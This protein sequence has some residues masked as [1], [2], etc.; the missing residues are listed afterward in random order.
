[1]GIWKEISD[2]IKAAGNNCDVVRRKYLRLLQ[3]YTGRN[4]I[5]YV[6]DFLEPERGKAGG[7]A[8]LDQNDKEGFL[9]IL[10]GLK[11]DKLDVLIHS[12]GGSA[13]AAEAIVTILRNQFA[14]IRFIIPNVAKSAAT[15]LAM[16]GNALVLDDKS[17]LGPI[18]PQFILRREGI[19]I[20]SP[21]QAILDQFEAA[22][23]EIADKPNLLPAW[24]PILNQ[25]G[26]SLIAECHNAT[27]LAT[28]LVAT[29]L[30]RYMFAGQADAATKAKRIADFLGNHR[31]FLSHRR[32]IGI[33]KAIELGLTVIDMRQ[34]PTLQRLV[35]QL[36]T[37]ISCTFDMTGA[38]KI[39]ENAQGA[40]LIRMVQQVPI[41]LPSA[42]GPASPPNGPGI[43]GPGPQLSRQQ[44]REQERLQK[45]QR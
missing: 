40:A 37:A 29:W 38:F 7:G 13:E 16:S 43:P 30:E 6:S 1:M 41:P 26:P 27:E 22:K 15:M 42:L 21:A 17:E 18:D 32:M 34:D 39:F 19:S 25:Y 5:I 31:N 23:K 36:Y 44:R 45:K 28:N 4:L 24:I 12:P 11:N 9:E 35:W 3:D 33:D 2:E 8:S 10:E 14:D 20:V